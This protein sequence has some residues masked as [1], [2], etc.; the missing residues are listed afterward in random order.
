MEAEYVYDENTKGRYFKLVQ[1]GNRVVAEPVKIPAHVLE[2]RKYAAWKAETSKSVAR[3][4]EHTRRLTPKK[5]LFYSVLLVLLSVV[6]AGYISVQ[7]EAYRRSGNIASLQS[8]IETLKS[9]NDVLE[10][11]IAAGVDFYEVKEAAAGK[12]GMVYPSEDQVIYYTIGDSDY[13]LQ[14]RSAGS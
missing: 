12:L 11:R 14:Y 4:L 2:E 9:S 1:N 6:C 3:N 5:I 7:T 8:R 13:M 10:K